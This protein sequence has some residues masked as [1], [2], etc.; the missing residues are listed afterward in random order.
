[1][2]LGDKTVFQMI[3]STEGNLDIADDEY[4]NIL[5][6]ELDESLSSFSVEND[7]LETMNVHYRTICFCDEVDFKSITLG[8]MQG[9]KQTDGTWFVQGKL[10]VQYS[11][12]NDEVNFDSQFTN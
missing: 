11:N 2:T 6:F 9:E 10:E 7:E 4:T 12:G 5:V 8:C 1:M 3:N